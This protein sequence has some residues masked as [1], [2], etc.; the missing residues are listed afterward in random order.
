MRKRMGESISLSLHLLK[1][2]RGNSDLIEYF[3]LGHMLAITIKRGILCFSS[4]VFMCKIYKKKVT[5][6]ISKTPKLPL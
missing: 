6:E 2:N 3:H 5:P 4:P 1:T